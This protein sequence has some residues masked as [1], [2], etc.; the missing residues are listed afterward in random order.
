MRRV[1]GD[2]YA[3]SNYRLSKLTGIHLDKFGYDVGRPDSWETQSVAASA[4]G[5]L[6][7]DSSE[8]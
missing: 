2:Y 5:E 6:S 3:E 1:I 7:G 4:K 8:A